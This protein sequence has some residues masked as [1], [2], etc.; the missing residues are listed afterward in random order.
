MKIENSL[1]GYVLLWG[2]MEETYEFFHA[3]IHRF[4]VRRI[5]RYWLP[6]Q[7]DDDFIWHIC[8]KMEV[9]GYTELP[10]PAVEP[11]K[12]RDLIITLMAQYTGISVMKIDIR[13]LNKAYRMVFGGNPLKRV[14]K[15]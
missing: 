4:C 14:R 9:E 10:N 3:H 1:E 5:L 2:K 11:R 13:A 15:L 7:A 8:M 6:E 12:C